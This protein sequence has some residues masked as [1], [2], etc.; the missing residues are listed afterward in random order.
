MATTEAAKQGVKTL[1]AQIRGV[2]AG[3]EDF[4]TWAEDLEGR[5]AELA[6][7]EASVAGLTK[8][9]DNLSAEITD[10]TARRAGEVVKTT[11]AAEQA[12]AVATEKAQAEL[13]DLVTRLDAAR[14]QAQKV[15]QESSARINEATAKVKLAESSLAE[16]QTKLEEATRALAS[17]KAK[18]G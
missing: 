16:T 5:E 2:F 4:V 9:R 17:L 13:H 18:L 14:E 6:L 15:E 3:F 7:K 8:E 12:V 10:L 11:Q 1:A